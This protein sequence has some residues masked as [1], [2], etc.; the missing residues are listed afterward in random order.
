MKNLAWTA[1]LALVIA[2]VWG[3]DQHRQLE[4]VR[5]EMSECKN[6]ESHLLTELEKRDLPTTQL[7]QPVH[8]IGLGCTNDVKEWMW[9]VQHGNPLIRLNHCN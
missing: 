6:I 1:V 7:S 3:Y 2:C 5:L 8:V 9:Q 4:Q